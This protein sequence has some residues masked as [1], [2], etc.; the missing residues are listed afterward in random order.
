MESEVES[1]SNDETEA[2]FLSKENQDGFI[3][4]V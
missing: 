4:T 1:N 3:D 2:F